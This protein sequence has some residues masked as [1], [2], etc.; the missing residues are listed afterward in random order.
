MKRKLWFGAACIVLAFTVTSCEDLGGCEQCKLV[1]RSSAGD[2]TSSG[3]ETEYCG[4]DL[5]TVKATPPVTVG[6]NTTTYECR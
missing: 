1:T 2:I 6:G 4:A 3:A 5:V